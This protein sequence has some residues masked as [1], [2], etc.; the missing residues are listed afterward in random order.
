M[1]SS[2]P[3]RSSM[4][5]SFKFDYDN[6][7]V[8]L[9]NSFLKYYNVPTFHCP[10]P[11]LDE[12]LSKNYKN[13][14]FIILD[15][16]GI[17]L[18]RQNLP[19]DSFIRKHITDQIF[20][21]F[22]PT[23]AAATTAF[24][25]GLTPYESGW[26]GWMSYYKQYNEII[27]NFRNTAFYS[28]KKLTTPPPA[29]NIIRY[30]TIYEKIITQN[31]EI[32]Y[33]KIFPAFDPNGV[34]SFEEMCKR[35]EV[36]SKQNNNRKLFSA[37]W[38][39]PDSSAHKYGT[40]AKEVKKIM[41]NL[42]EN[43]EKLAK[44]LKNALLVVSA[45]HGQTD[46]EEIYLNSAYPELCEMFVRPPAFEARFVTFFIKNKKIKDFE[47]KFNDLFSEDFIL[48]NKADFLKSGILGSGK[49]HK[50]VPEFIGDYVAISYGNRSLRYATGEKEHKSLKADHAGMSEKEMLVPLILIEKN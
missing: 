45:D 24:H 49:M 6:S 13:V 16:M 30:E 38:T 26:L 12:K 19:Q 34:E 42:D 41:L 17:D 14:I 27:E 4:D 46:V 28:G 47:K 43:L 31:P 37:Y 2:F 15:G 5:K 40:T 18:I 21:V 9:S 11:I 20:S 33:H 35:I 25:S 29:N 36:L 48:W 22:P 50:Q 44:N 10:L 23:T 32:E 7:I 39:E 1:L 3:R 8:S